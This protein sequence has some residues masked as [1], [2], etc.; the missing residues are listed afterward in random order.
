MKVYE[1]RTGKLVAHR[2]VQISG[3]SCPSKLHYTTPYGLTDIGPPSDVQVKASDGD[4]RAAF[5]SLI[6]R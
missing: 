4:V 3:S 5:R 2:K 1:L 6:Q